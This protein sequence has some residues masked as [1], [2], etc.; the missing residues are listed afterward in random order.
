[1]ETKVALDAHARRKSNEP[2]PINRAGIEAEG[3]A[4]VRFAPTSPLGER[5]EASPARADK[6]SSGWRQT[7]GR[8]CSVFSGL[9]FLLRLFPFN[10]DFAQVAGV[11]AVEGFCQRFLQRSRLRKAHRHANPCNRLQDR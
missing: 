3:W 1:M 11:L 8:V 10:D 4:G 6:S 7:P 5:I 2:R 9:L